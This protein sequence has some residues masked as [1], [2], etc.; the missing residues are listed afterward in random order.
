M[1]DDPT[2]IGRSDPVAGI[3]PHQGPDPLPTFPVRILVLD[4]DPA[5]LQLYQ[6]ALTQRSSAGP[7][8]DIT[9]CRNGDQALASVQN[10]K[11]ADRPFAVAFVDIDLGP[12]PDG[13][14]VGRRIREVDPFVNFVVVTGRPDLFP[15]EHGPLIAPQDKLLFMQKPMQIQEIRQ[16]VLALG[17]KW[18]SERMLVSANAEL[19]QKINEL[20]KSRRELLANKAEM[21]ALNAQLMETNNALSVLARNLE[22][23]R[24]ASEKRMLQRSRTLVLPIIQ[25]LRQNGRLNRY[26]HDLDLLELYIRDLSTDMSGD[27]KIAAALSAAEM[28]VAALIK[29][30]MTSEQIARHLFIS[31]STVKT[32]RKNIRRKIR[33]TKTNQNLKTFLAS[34][35][36]TG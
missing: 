14:V 6:A 1:A 19:D 18:C 10:A 20:E 4:D 33:L 8:F 7:C 21:E 26:R 34:Q 25:R 36:I 12:G 28:R 16:F 27:V 22:N 35:M 11:E 30:G 3:T 23:S 17:A 24:I 2:V 32:H 9:L 13:I 15:H 31:L 29:N 5:L